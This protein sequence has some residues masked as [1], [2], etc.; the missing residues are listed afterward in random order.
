MVGGKR[1]HWPQQ[2]PLT[3]GFTAE[4]IESLRVTSWGVGGAAD[5]AISV[6]FELI[7]M[8]IEEMRSFVGELDDVERGARRGV[9]KLSGAT[10][11]HVVTHRD[12]NA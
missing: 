5:C 10:R 12:G 8:T 11:G 4:W 9:G 1:L 3:L 6:R 7:V 2:P